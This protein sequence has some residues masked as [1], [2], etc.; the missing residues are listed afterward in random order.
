M[1]TIIL[2]YILLDNADAISD[3]ENTGPLLSKIAKLSKLREFHAIMHCYPLLYYV[4]SEARPALDRAE[5]NLEAVV[6]SAMARR[7]GT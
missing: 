5:R 4:D 7:K 3:P 6:T 2:S 1:L